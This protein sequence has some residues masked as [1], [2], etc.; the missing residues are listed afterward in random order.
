M[1]IT[2]FMGALRLWDGWLG[3]SKGQSLLEILRDRDAHTPL[4]KHLCL[5]AVNYGRH[6]NAVY[7]FHDDN[8][9]S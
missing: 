4:D 2:D 7:P 3:G 9:E 1:H 8:E 5:S 6:R